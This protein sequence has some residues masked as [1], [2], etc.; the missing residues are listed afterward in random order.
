MGL[1]AE[2]VK[3]T[4]SILKKHPKVLVLYLTLLVLSQLQNTPFIAFQLLL[5]PLVIFY[6]LLYTA[7]IPLVVKD[8]TSSKPVSIMKSLSFGLKKLHKILGLILLISLPVLVFGS[9][10][11]FFAAS[12]VLT[13]QPFLIWI[14]AIFIP[15][16]IIT[17]IY[18]CIR[19]AFSTSILMIENQG[20]INSIKKSWEVSRNKFW[21]IVGAFSLLSLLLIPYLIAVPVFVFISALTRLSGGV[22]TSF[23]LIQFII[24]LLLLLVPA[25]LLSLLPT[26]YY[27]K[28]RGRK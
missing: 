19:L 3:A 17:A 7:T 27:L 28:I 9:L 10:F 25:T 23:L 15:G 4:F 24:S 13:G 12:L 6:I 11:G 21:S 8:A 14:L 16:I 18:I 26:A 1:A 20:I 2:S 22:S 5:F